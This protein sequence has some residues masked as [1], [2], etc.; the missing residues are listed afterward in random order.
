MESLDLTI[1]ECPV[2]SIPVYLMPFALWTQGA[3]TNLRAKPR[4]QLTRPSL[5]YALVAFSES[6][7]IR[8]APN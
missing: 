7:A 2:S 3:K 1:E 4:P 8:E 5:F 6:Q